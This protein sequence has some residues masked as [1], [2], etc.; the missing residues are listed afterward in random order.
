MLERFKWQLDELASRFTESPDTV[1]E[2]VGITPSLRVRELA[3]SETFF[4]PVLLD[5]VPVRDGISLGCGH[6]FSWRTFEGLFLEAV[7]TPRQVSQL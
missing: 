2:L 1:L 3:A 4:D 7:A 6:L 5:D